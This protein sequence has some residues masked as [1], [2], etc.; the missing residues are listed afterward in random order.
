VNRHWEVTMAGG[1]AS[2]GET[3]VHPEGLLWWAVGGELVGESP[4]RLGFLREVMTVAPFQQLVP[5]PESVL[6][7]SALIE[8][9]EYYL[10]RFPT[11]DEP[12]QIRIDGAETFKVELI[13][14]WQMKIYALGFTDAGVQAFVPVFVPC[15]FRF[16]RAAQPV[17]PLAFGTV[18]QLLARFIG[19]TVSAP[20]LPLRSFIEQPERFSADFTLRQLMADERTAAIIEKHIPDSAKIKDALPSGAW[21]LSELR[22]RSAAAEACRDKPDELPCLTAE[23]FAAISADL[24]KILVKIDADEKA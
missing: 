12:T 5:A 7:G 4:A 19:D 14:P 20:P 23:S 16:T 13:D 6:G 3:Y 10:F 2:H 21:P 8:P 1:Y 24:A 11:L 18:A 22:R 17:E 9:S 15:L